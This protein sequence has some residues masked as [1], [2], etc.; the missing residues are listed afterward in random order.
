MKLNFG[1]KIAILYGAF[2]VFIVFFVVKSFG[3]SF[4]LEEENYYEKEIHFEE[5]MDAIK[6]FNDLGVSININQKDSLFIQFPDFFNK[7]THQNVNVLFKR[8]SDKNL[9]IAFTLP[10]DKIN[11][12][13]DLKHFKKGVY[14]VEISFTVDSIYYLNKQKIFLT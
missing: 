6:N 5:E 4:D 8:P 11:Q 10:M 14:T 1:F 12:T 3:V 13:I 7:L 9:D 2:V